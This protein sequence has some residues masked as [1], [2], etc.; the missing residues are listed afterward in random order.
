MR[1][2]LRIPVPYLSNLCLQWQNSYLR[3]TPTCKK[4]KLFWYRRIL[5]QRSHDQETRTLVS[6]KRQSQ[7]LKANDSLCTDQVRW[8]HYTLNVQWEGRIADDWGRVCT[9]EWG[10]RKHV[11][12]VDDILSA[13][14]VWVQGMKFFTVVKCWLW[15]GMIALNV[16]GFA[17]LSGSLMKALSLFCHGRFSKTDLMMR[18]RKY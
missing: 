15:Y 4:K 6:C 17:C 3:K 2:F 12:C 14:S 18:K 1:I 5:N 11:S 13:A 9:R 16:V 7:L 10:C 8:D